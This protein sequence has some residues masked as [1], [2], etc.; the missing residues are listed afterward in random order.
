MANRG[1]GGDRKFEAT[2]DATGGAYGSFLEAHGFSVLT[3]ASE[4][5]VKP[6]WPGDR[7]LVLAT[8]AAQDRGRTIIGR[9]VNQFVVDK[10]SATAAFV[11]ISRPA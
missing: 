8:P 2:S 11:G 7:P 4:W 6:G 3:L 5:D 9:V 1:H 10:P